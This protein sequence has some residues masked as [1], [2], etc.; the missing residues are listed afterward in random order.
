MNNISANFLPSMVTDSNNNS[1]DAGV[2]CAIAMFDL[3]EASSVLPHAESVVKNVIEK[4]FSSRPSTQSKGKTLVL[5]IIEI[6]DPTVS[7]TALMEKF[8]DKRPKI[9]PLCIETIL[10]GFALYGA[11]CFPLKDLLKAIQP[12]FNSSNNAARDQAMV[13]VTTLAKWVGPAPILPMLENLRPAQK[14]EIEKSLSEID[15]SSR[16]VPTLFLKKDRESGL[17]NASESSSG[18]GKSKASSVDNL[19]LIEEVDLAKKLKS[20]EFADLMRSEKWVEHSQGLQMIIDAIGPTPKLKPWAMTADIVKGCKEYM[21]WGHLQVQSK[22]L[23]LLTLFSLGL[24]TKFSVEGRG[25]MPFV[26]M[27]AKEKKVVDDVEEACLAMF[28]NSFSVDPFTEDICEQL[29]SKKSPT[30]SKICMQHIIRNVIEF[31]PVQPDNIRLMVDTVSTCIDDS[32]PK[33]RESTIQVLAALYQF[34]QAGTGGNNKEVATIIQQYQVSRAK[35][36]AKIVSAD[37]SAGAADAAAKP[38]AVAASKAPSSVP[39]RTASKPS[40]AADQKEVEHSKPAAVAASKKGST[41]KGIGKEDRGDNIPLNID[42]VEHFAISPDRVEALVTDL[43]GEEYAS[44][45]SGLADAKWQSK[46]DS[47]GS[48]S[49][50]LASKDEVQ[51]E[52]LKAVLLHISA[53]TTKFKMNNMNVVKAAME[54]CALICSKTSEKVVVASILDTFAEKI[55]DKKMLPSFEDILRRS[56][57]SV[58]Y[59]FP[60]ARVYS[61]L[62]SIK[63][64]LAHQHFLIWMKQY[65]SENGVAGLQLN[66][67]TAFLVKELENKQGSIRSASIE[68]LAEFYHYLGPPFQALLNGFD[69]PGPAKSSIDAEFNKIGYDPTLSKKV[70]AVSGNAQASDGAIPRVDLSNALDKAIL[71]NMGATDGKDSWQ[72]RKAAIEKV[73]QACESS[74]HYIEMN[75]FI[76]EVVKSLKARFLDTQSNIR[77]LALTTLAKVVASLDDDSAVKV[78]KASVAAVLGG[79]SDSK[80]VI[81]DAAIAALQTMVVGADSANPAAKPTH[82]LCMIPAICEWVSTS[83]ARGDVLAWLATHLDCFNGADV[84]E[85][86][87]CL[88]E[89]LQDKNSVARVNAESLLSYFMQHNLINP[90]H[91]DKSVR[92]LPTA[93]KKSIQPFIDRVLMKFSRNAPLPVPERVVAPPTVTAATVTLPA[94]AAASAAVVEDVRVVKPPVVPDEVPKTTTFDLPATVSGSKSERIRSASQLGEDSLA[95]LSQDWFAH[96]ENVALSQVLFGAS[97]P[98]EAAK[99]FVSWVQ[100]PRFIQ[101]SDLCFRWLGLQFSRNIMLGGVFDRFLH[102][103]TLFMDGLRSLPKAVKHQLD[104]REVTFFLPKLLHF[105]KNLTDLQ[106]QNCSAVVSCS[107]DCFP[108]S[109]VAAHLLDGLD[110]PHIDCRRI[111]LNEVLR[112]NENVGF[113]ALG[114][115]ALRKMSQLLRSV[116]KSD[117]SFVLIQR[118]AVALAESV[119]FDARRLFEVYPGDLFDLKSLQK[120]VSLEGADDLDGVDNSEF[121]K[122]TV[123]DLLSRLNEMMLVPDLTACSDV[124]L[125][126]MVFFAEKDASFFASISKL[127]LP[128]EDI[129]DNVQLCATLVERLVG[130]YASKQSLT[131]QILLTCLVTVLQRLLP[132]AV[133]SLDSQNVHKLLADLLESSRRMRTC[134][135]AQGG[136]QQ[137]LNGLLIQ[138]AFGVD[139]VVFFECL[140]SL[141]TSSTWLR[142]PLLR[143]LQ[144]FVERKV[145]KT[146]E[147]KSL[148][149]LLKTVEKC[150]KLVNSTAIFSTSSVE[151]HTFLVK[152]VYQG[153]RDIYGENILLEVLEQ[154]APNTIVLFSPT[155]VHVPEEDIRSFSAV[156]EN[157][158]PPN[159][160]I[161]QKATTSRSNES[162]EKVLALVN[163]ITVSRDKTASIK[164]LY[165]LKQRDPSLDIE[166]YLDKLSSTFR[167][168]VLDEFSRLDVQQD[169]DDA[170]QSISQLQSPDVTEGA[171]ALRI[172]ENLKSARPVMSSIADLDTSVDTSADTVPDLSFSAK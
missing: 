122:L 40:A 164:E 114:H 135:V 10:E 155:A 29:K 64:P 120:F 28:K 161:Q 133:S 31:T 58:G 87:P 150:E 100:D 89:S 44:I 159:N 160:N 154:V 79:V 30:H 96:G 20:G 138:V 94:K 68:V 22:A 15:S 36:Y 106:R 78:I 62:E 41:G 127:G 63:A 136:I 1:L 112:L 105:C 9:P 56:I 169:H 101:Q 13:F 66:G 55:S 152:L 85:M 103:L 5:K 168:Y 165:L 119:D 143:L 21:T 118:L 67:A 128:E 42:M 76:P 170:T 83:T 141:V 46:V 65:V 7:C 82:L 3:C 48:I 84:A 97:M 102:Q 126:E 125:R 147:S 57:A 6:S 25:I 92:D 117:S 47:M 49:R 104:A 157:M 71:T 91:V 162:D 33:V 111:C 45:N 53:A 77:P 167:R 144:V 8:S 61:Q 88:V 142:R 11:S 27:K 132:Y 4:C 73:A 34:S 124:V 93:A 156:N 14:T 19:D 50:I 121:D 148:D 130:Q 116:H 166:K 95:I 110:S 38:A 171:E 59:N 172:I 149:Q 80:K 81:K 131:S 52:G 146:K 37:S 134:P 32:D 151:S 109:S 24:K 98:D 108:P 43:L 145:Y 54:L 86:V 137:S 2:D 139:S 113:M 69:V 129:V 16:P 123:D 72:V 90:S 163:E 39:A 35:L 18:K 74:A 23:K 158:A 12:V 60:V 115:E 17:A 75:K 153:L 107:S 99:L 26:L 70:A 140:T 51:E